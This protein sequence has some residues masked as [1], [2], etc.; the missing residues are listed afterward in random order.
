MI[1]RRLTPVGQNL[2]GKLA[3]APVLASKILDISISTT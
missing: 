1:T 3:A 2:G